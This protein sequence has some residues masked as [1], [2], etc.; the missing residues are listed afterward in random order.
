MLQKNNKDE[1]SDNLVRIEKPMSVKEAADFLNC[2][3]SLIYK[4]THCRKIKHFKRGKFCFFMLKDL[5][6]YAFECP[7]KTK[8]ELDE[9]VNIFL[10]RKG[11]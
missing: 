2:S 8:E 3:T 7:V 4:L 5:Q 6:D 11:V 10:L 1:N 9:E